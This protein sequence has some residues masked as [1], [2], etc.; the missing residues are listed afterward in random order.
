M[1]HL[2]LTPQ[3]IH[4][5]GGYGVRA[6]SEV[7]A[8]KLIADAQALEKAGCFAVVLEKIPASVAQCRKRPAEAG[9][10]LFV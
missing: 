5:F 9:R 10:F 1:G 6:R 4:K 3:S 8:T 7:E 2:G